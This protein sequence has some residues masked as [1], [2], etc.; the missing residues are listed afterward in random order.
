MVNTIT[1]KKEREREREKVQMENEERGKETKRC[2]KMRE[3]GNK[4]KT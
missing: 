4:W 3:I 1:G 2:D